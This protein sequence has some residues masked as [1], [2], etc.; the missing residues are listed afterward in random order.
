MWNRAEQ[1]LRKIGGVI[2]IA[3]II[4]WVLGY[5]PRTTENDP[6]YNS[7]IATIQDQYSKQ[8]L[9]TQQSE[10]II[11]QIRVQEQK[12]INQVNV[13]RESERQ[14]NSYIGAM[15]RFVEPVMKPLGFDWKMSVAIITGVAAKEITIGTL[16]VLYQTDLESDE[17]S[18]SLIER[19]QEQ[20][21]QVGP[22]KGEKVFSPLV[23]F[24]FMLFILIYFPC[25]AVVAAI[26]KE[27]GDW[28]WALFIV[29]YTTALAYLASLLVYQ[30]GS[31]FV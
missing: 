5:F 2:L 31:L 24:S 12:D 15:G 30:V 22:K 3:S 6:E 17:G 23:A 9:Q 16:G 14:M 8:I 1:Y 10:D 26:R 11:A 18:A 20:T 28:R 4:I 19:I 21:Y 29:V 13:I 25:V 27:S 7:Q